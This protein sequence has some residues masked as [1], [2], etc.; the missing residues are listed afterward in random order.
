MYQGHGQ[1][2]NICSLEMLS[3]FFEMNSRKGH[4]RLFM[5]I[6]ASIIDGPNKDMIVYFTVQL[7]YIFLFHFSLTKTKL[8]LL[9]VLSRMFYINFRHM[10]LKV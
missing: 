7:K 2:N 3:K 8:L 5:S 1:D 10:D 4:V 9:E 6:L